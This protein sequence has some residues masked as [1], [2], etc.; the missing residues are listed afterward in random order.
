MSLKTGLW[1]GEKVRLT[2][3]TKND[4]PTMLRWWQ[5][6]DFLRLYD[7]FPAF[8]QTPEKLEERITD[9]GQGVRDFLF[10]IRPLN[11]DILL[12]ILELDGV[13][14]AHGNTFLSIAIGERANRGQGYGTE[15]VSLALGYAFNEL[16]LHRVCLNVMSYNTNAIA[17][18]EKLGFTKEGIQ[19][20]H[21]KK[22]GQHFDMIFYGMLSREWL[23]NDE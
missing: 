15:A 2:A 12:G 14:W 22:D 17:L 4:I 16:N 19:R 18:Y 11:D 5:D 23:Q 8:W 1:R 21:V 3:V 20:E 6:I 13:Q 7:S 10:G 9:S